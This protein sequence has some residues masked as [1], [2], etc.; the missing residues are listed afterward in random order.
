[1][2]HSS[3]SCTSFKDNVW[4]RFNICCRK[5]STSN[6]FV[7]HIGTSTQWTNYME[8]ILNLLTDNHDSFSETI[9][10]VSMP[11]HPFLMCDIPLLDCNTGFC[12]LSY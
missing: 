5:I 3:S 7:A 9:P 2:G 8:R 4:V 6:V 10:L 11:E 12:T 1:M